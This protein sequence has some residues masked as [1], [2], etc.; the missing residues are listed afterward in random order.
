MWKSIIFSILFFSLLI[1]NL[2]ANTQS[3]VA[4]EDVRLEYAHSLVSHITDT[5]VYLTS[6]DNF[7]DSVVVK[8]KIN[9]DGEIVE[10]TITQ[11]A[12]YKNLENEVL[13][14]ITLMQPFP[15]MPA[16]FHKDAE[17]AIFSYQFTPT[18]IKAD[19]KDAKDFLK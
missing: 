3:R 12:S 8:L 17:F 11:K 1:T 7:K 10:K 13:R 19:I 5:W 14:Q 18:G 6:L 4:S 15:K 9:R 2:N 16:E